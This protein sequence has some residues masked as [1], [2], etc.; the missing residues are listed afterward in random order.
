MMTQRMRPIYAAFLLSFLAVGV[1]ILL[2]GD[3]VEDAQLAARYT[4]RVAFPIFL[5]AYC[6]S[7][8]AYLWPNETIRGVM[9]TRR[10]WGLGFALAH[11]IHLVALI[12]YL[13][14]SGATPAV[15]SL[16][17]GGTAYVLI[18][19]MAATSNDASM[20]R[21]G[22]WWKRLHRFGMHWIWL[23]FTLSYL[24]RSVDPEAMAQGVALF[25]FAAAAGLIRLTAWM[26]RRR[27]TH[28]A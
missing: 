25:P 18:A 23:V 4:A 1:G 13:R 22:I 20:R 5:V 9:R 8:I 26:K 12:T 15:L 27:R 7:S 2:G 21:M 28:M 19:A 10:Q 3:R 11:G 16:A 6:A 14:I 24:K 17:F